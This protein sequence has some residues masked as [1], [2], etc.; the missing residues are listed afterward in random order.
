[1]EFC[2][3][4]FHVNFFEHHFGL[5]SFIETSEDSCGFTLAEHFS[6]HNLYSIV[7]WFLTQYWHRW[8]LFGFLEGYTSREIKVEKTPP[9]VSL[10]LTARS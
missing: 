10:V 4:L 6:K 9:L 7:L 2:S 5:L 3:L 8:S 1:M